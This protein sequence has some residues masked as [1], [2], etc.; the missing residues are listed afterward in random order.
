YRT[1]SRSF[2]MGSRYSGVRVPRASD[3][4]LMDNPPLSRALSST[5]TNVQMVSCVRAETRFPL[6]LPT[7]PDSSDLRSQ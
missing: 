5:S 2:P 1:Y 7:T 6:L 4:R 3:G